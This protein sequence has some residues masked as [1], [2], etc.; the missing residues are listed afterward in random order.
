[1]SG[2][3]EQ[4]STPSN[5]VGVERRFDVD[6]H[7]ECAKSE[8]HDPVYGGDSDQFADFSGKIKD[9]AEQIWLAGLGA[10]TKVENEG[11]KWFDTLVKD[12]ERLEER[13]RHLVDRQRSFYRDKVNEVRGKVEE[14]KD[15]AS[16][17]I[18]RIEKV[19]DERV[20]FA[21][22]RLNIPSKKD[23]D[24]LID[25]LTRLEHEVMAL[26]AERAAV[27]PESSSVQADGVCTEAVCAETKE[28]S[29]S[30]ASSPK[31]K[32]SAKRSSGDK[33]S[34]AKSSKNRSSRMT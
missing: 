30:T 13:T 6:G 33:S 1:M 9:V 14:V 31:T 29:S 32:S 2:E 16:T 17:S 21:L 22:A 7:D 8:H 5:G 23:M 28:P 12:G 34:S 27:L 19:F 26:K 10:Y 3:K 25:Q 20:S 18:D 15:K 24:R 4:A 11:T